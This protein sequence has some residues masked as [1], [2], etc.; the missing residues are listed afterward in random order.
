MGRVTLNQ[1]YRGPSATMS[2]ATVLNKGGMSGC[3]STP[4]IVHYSF[5]PRCQPTCTPPSWPDCVLFLFFY[6]YAQRLQHISEGATVSHE[7]AAVIWKDNVLP[8]TPW[9]VVVPS[10]K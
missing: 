1:F 5:L 10:E 4:F 7:R 3:R 2:C 6:S 8:C 9:T